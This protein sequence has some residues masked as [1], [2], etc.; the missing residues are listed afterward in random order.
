MKQTEQIS[1]GMSDLDGILNFLLSGDNVV[2]NT[3]SIDEYK[4]FVTPYVNNAISKGHTVHY[5]RFADHA[6]VVDETL[7]KVIVHKLDA[8]TGFETFAKEVHEHINEA[9][10]GAYF[11][12][13]CLTSLL[14]YWATDNMVANL[15]L[16]TCPYLYRMDAIAY[17]AVLKNSHS[18]NTIGKIKDT[19]QI[20][21]SIYNYDGTCYVHPQKVFERSSPTMFLPHQMCA[22]GLFRAVA[23][24]I[25]ATSLFYT[26]CSVNTNTHKKLDAWDRLMLRAKETA[27]SGSEE[28]RTEIMD[29]IC[30]AIIGR[31]ERIIE[32][33]KKHFSLRDILEIKSRM[34]GTGF[35]G[36]K[37][38]GMLLS[39]KIL[40]NSKDRD[41]YDLLE[42]HDSYFVGSDV[43]HTYIIHNGWWDLYMEHRTEKGYFRA[44]ERLEQLMLNG[45]FP[46]EIEE[47]F[48]AM[49]DYFGQYPIV[50]RSSSILEDGF[51][52]AFAGKYES[53]FC[54]VQG[55][56]KTR[57][58]EFLNNLRRVYSS[59]MCH[60][61]LEY[62][63]KKGLEKSDEQMGL[64]IQRVSGCFHGYYYYPNV[65]GV[66]LS[67]NTYVWHDDIQPEAGML[68]LVVGLGTRAVNRVKDDYPRIVALNAPEIVPVNEAADIKKFS[69]RDLDVLDTRVS[70]KNAVSL[71]QI[72]DESFPFDL[73]KVAVHDR[74]AERML[75]DRGRPRKDIWI[76][77]FDRLLKKT[78]FP[79]VM[80]DLMNTIEDEYEYP[81]DIEF[82]IN[83]TNEDNY[84]INLV[85]C[86]PH[87]T[88]IISGDNDSDIKDLGSFDTIFKSKSNF[89][90]GNVL[91]KLQQVIYVEPSEY[92]KLDERE[93]FA[94]ARAIRAINRGIEK[95]KRHTLL[96]GPGRWGTSTPSLGVPVNF[97]D[98]SHMSA[99]GEIEFEEGGLMPELSFGSHFFQDLV[100]SNIFFMALFPS[101]LDCTFSKDVFSEFKN[102]FAEAVPEMEE[103][104]N[105]VKLYRF[106]EDFLVL[107][108]EIKSQDLRILRK[109]I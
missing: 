104:Q 21:I 90:G 13:D 37:A 108:S 79:K 40:T 89:M 32:L 105:V 31:D 86:R 26:I 45:E 43:F 92:I 62:R 4:T 44:G 61:A 69:Q 19:T 78:E 48:E 72:Y 109:K 84:K 64:L 20:Y 68:R 59:T 96:L 57:Y 74:V 41:W 51:G 42:A 10:R 66:G 75:A 99:I 70:G 14:S 17:F 91:M 16:V 25:E 35:I 98:I 58:K 7:D 100:E 71:Y 63:K 49:L 28:E 60:D 85:Q 38:V 106:D 3:P 65:A 93:K 52:N 23:N 6:P 33:V 36:G 12:F 82:T 11:V 80:Q 55:S 46:P 30:R 29:K 77:T 54:S 107:N 47:H 34:I 24:S 53:F 81:V 97:A 1:T 95:C 88:N 101:S 102:V 50:V 76:L 18:F 39:R 22:D 56:P 67:Y 27:A 103:F 5:I 83:F 9:G 73:N 2:W 15:F 94:V 87:Q 8:K